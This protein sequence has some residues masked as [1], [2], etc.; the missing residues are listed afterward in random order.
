MEQKRSISKRMRLAK[1][2]GKEYKNNEQVAFP[3]LTDVPSPL[4]DASNSD[5]FSASFENDGSSEQSDTALARHFSVSTASSRGSSLRRTSVASSLRL[6]R[7]TSSSSSST[8]SDNN[9]SS[10]PTLSDSPESNTDLLSPICSDEEVDMLTESS[11]DAI[12]TAI[13][14]KVTGHEELQTGSK[15]AL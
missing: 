11:A 13:L 10:C 15:W 4:S 6:R 14:E 8:K 9:G 7:R 3:A 5:V 1:L 12:A 2:W